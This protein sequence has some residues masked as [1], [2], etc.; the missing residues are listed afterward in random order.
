[1]F[2][3]L[4]VLVRFEMKVSFSKN[5]KKLQHFG[6]KIA[7]IEELFYKPKNDCRYIYN[8]RNKDQTTFTFSRISM[9]KKKVYDLVSRRDRN[10][11]GCSVDEIIPCLPR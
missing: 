1:M 9:L 5:K 11:I 6:K 10:I 4:A 7:I 8:T 2:V 3:L